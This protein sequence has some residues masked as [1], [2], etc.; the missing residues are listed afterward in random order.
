MFTNF[1][2]AAIS[3]VGKKAPSNIIVNSL[4]KEHF[5]KASY[6]ANT[7][8]RQYYYS[9]NISSVTKAPLA[10]F[11]YLSIVGSLTK[12]R[13]Y[14]RRKSLELCLSPT[15]KQASSNIQDSYKG[16]LS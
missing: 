6:A 3:I 14:S 5:K 11:S 13:R 10:T 1:I 16:F 9:T 8:K 4:V 12:S 15:Y 7:K 2:K